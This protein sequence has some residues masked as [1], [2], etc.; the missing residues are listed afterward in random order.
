MAVY[1]KKPVEVEAVRWLG[2]NEAEMDE[3]LTWPHRYEAAD[4]GDFLVFL[5]IRTLGGLVDAK[6]GDWV[7][8]TSLGGYR[9]CRPDIF[10]ATYEE[11]TD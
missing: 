8:K 9:V 1:R 7:I 4:S 11:V 3:F 10:D 6:P 2:N 5:F